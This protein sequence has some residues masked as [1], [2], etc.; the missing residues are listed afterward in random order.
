MGVLAKVGVS[1]GKYAKIYESW[2]KLRKVGV[3][4]G[5]KKRKFTGARQ[6]D[7]EKD[8]FGPFAMGFQLGD[9]PLQCCLP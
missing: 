5:R 9:D 3:N 1:W 8:I 2:R 4:A 7:G 6:G